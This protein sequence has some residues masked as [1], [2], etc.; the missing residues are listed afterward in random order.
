ME[1]FGGAY[2]IAVGS[3]NGG[4]HNMSRWLRPL[5]DRATLDEYVEHIVYNETRIYVKK[6]VANYAE[7][8]RRYEG[9]HA[10]VRLPSL[11]E[12]DDPTVINF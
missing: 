6:V 8:V 3:Y 11:P 9:E 2:P 10:T 4:P 12:M 1:R 5:K 7:Y